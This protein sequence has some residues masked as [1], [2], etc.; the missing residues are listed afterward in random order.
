[1]LLSTRDEEE[2]GAAAIGRS[3]LGTNTH[4][5]SVHNVRSKLIRKTADRKPDEILDAVGIVGRIVE[6]FRKNI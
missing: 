3:V 2:A 6:S 1:M 4:E 5:M